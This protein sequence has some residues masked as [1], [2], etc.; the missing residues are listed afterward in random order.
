M[1]LADPPYTYSEE[2]LQI[3]MKRLIDYNVVKEG[4]ILILEH[5]N[6]KNLFSTDDLEK[7]KEG[8]YGKTTVSFLRRKSA[9]NRSISG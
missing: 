4:G 3:F 5:A 2:D 6:I 9:E 1:V 7:Y 8:K